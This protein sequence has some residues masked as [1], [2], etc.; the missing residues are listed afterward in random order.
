MNRWI[1]VVVSALLLGGACVTQDDFCS[2]RYQ[3]C[4]LRYSRDYGYYRECYSPANYCF[5]DMGTSERST[6][7]DDPQAS[8]PPPDSTEE[9]GSGGN[10]EPG[11]TGDEGGGAGSESEG[12]DLDDGE[13]D[14][15]GTAQG[16]GTDR[17]SAFEFPCSRDSQCGP[18]RCLEGDCYYG[19]HS[20]E[21]CG[22]GDRCAVESGMRICLPDPNPPVECTRSA[23][24]GTS[25]VC[26]NGSCRQQC[27]STSQCDNVFDRCL[28]SI[29]A[30]D[31][32]PLGECVLDL[33]CAEGLVCLD[34]ECVA[35]CSAQAADGE[36]CGGRDT[37]DLQPDEPD[38]TE[39]EDD[40]EDP[41]PEES[42]QG[43][44]AGALPPI[45]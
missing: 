12:E 10:E 27:T 16:P 37:P 41:G 14:N 9:D 17:Y 11:A 36:M 42:A 23:Q 28:S 2:P 5:Y 31:R 34:G 40:D 30:P 29:C 15:A 33:E 39:S 45:E 6:M 3:Q 19:C 1:P 35:A 22:S 44:D 26:L 32:R 21:Q 13:E 8:T 18:G 43:P 7:G 4:N 25:E 24:C 20:D 38:P